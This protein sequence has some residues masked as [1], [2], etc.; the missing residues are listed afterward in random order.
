LE[1]GVIDKCGW[2]VDTL[3]M[4]YFLLYPEGWELSGSILMH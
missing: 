3:V 1:K 2:W 4:Q